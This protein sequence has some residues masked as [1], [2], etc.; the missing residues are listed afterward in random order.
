MNNPEKLDESLLKRFKS[1]DKDAANELL[2]KYFSRTVEAAR[3]RISTRNLRGTG[4]EDI[5]LSVFESIWKKAENQHFSDEDL[6]N[7]DEFWRLLC[8]M[9]RHKAESHVRRE[10]AKKRGG[11]QVRGESIFVNAAGDQSPGISN[12]KN[13]GLTP[14]EL[15]QFADQ[16]RVMMNSLNDSVLQEIVTLRMEEYKV[17]EI[18]DHFD[19]SERWVKRKLALIRD[20]WQAEVDQLDVFRAE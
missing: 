1:G 6:S 11:G 19:K 8:T 5:A 3:R 9:I 2:S 10:T 7:S 13:D 12:Q 14:D 16:H 15:A 20:I 18:A 4:S 17:S